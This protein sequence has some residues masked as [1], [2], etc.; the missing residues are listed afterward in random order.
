MKKIV[1]YLFLL[2]SI[3]VLGQKSKSF[4][5]PG[6]VKLNEVLFVDKTE[7]TNISYREYMYWNRKYKGEDS[8]EYISCLPD[9]SVWNEPM[10]SLY[11]R[12]PSYS[13]YPIVGISYEQAIAYCKW[14][15]DRV[16]ESLYLKENKLD[17]STDLSDVSIPEKV[18]YRLPT[19]EEWE[20]IAKINYSNKTL[21]KLDSK[22]FSS[23]SHYNYAGDDI[24]DINSDRSQITCPVEFYWPNSIGIFCIKGNVAE[25]TSDLGVAKGGSWKHKENEYSI[26]KNY[27]Y[28]KPEVW[29]GFRCVCE[30][31]Y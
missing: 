25:M 31:L 5:P 6:T 20:E 27:L 18:K 19:V 4:I 11:L 22:K 21:K 3:S 14:R 10:K 28:D 24:E 17:Y 16:N 29:L 15:S 2:L 9:T 23:K 13:E 1:L 8:Q 12:H 30:V 26:E 7:I